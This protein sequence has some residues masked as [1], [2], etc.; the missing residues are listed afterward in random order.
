MS[1]N[2]EKKQ[3]KISEV[4]LMLES[5]KDRKT[6]RKELGLNAAQGSVLFKHEALKGKRVRKG[7]ENLE[8]IDDAPAKESGKEQETATEASNETSSN[9]GSNEASTEGT[10]L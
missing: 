8:I 10:F 4:L 2:T 9:E 3:V 7:V 5:G 1:D 6:I